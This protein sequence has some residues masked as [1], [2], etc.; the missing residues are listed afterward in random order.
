[1]VDMD[2]TLIEAVLDNDKRYS[3]AWGNLVSYKDKYGNM[4]KLRVHI[5][6]NAIAMVKE[7]VE[8]GHHYIV[9]SAGEYYYVHAVINYFN[10]KSGVWPEIIYT[11]GDMVSDGKSN[12]KY[13]SMQAMGY[14]NFIIVD[15][16]PDLIIPSERD[17]II[18]IKSWTMEQHTDSDL[19]WVSKLMKL[20]GNTIP[21]II[22]PRKIRFVLTDLE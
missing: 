8:N 12:N 16:N 2:Q 21:I 11:R 13:K 17:R 18:K 19:D 9:W 14:D 4:V 6:P 5:R 1:M 15:D 22:K 10:N 20:Y 3:K 7:I